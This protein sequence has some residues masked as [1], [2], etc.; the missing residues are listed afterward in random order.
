M[1]SILF[2]R[3]LFDQ[4]SHAVSPMRVISGE[5]FWKRNVLHLIT[6]IFPTRHFHKAP[7]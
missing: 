6:R 1:L 4:H 3:Q 2:A 5:E 7:L